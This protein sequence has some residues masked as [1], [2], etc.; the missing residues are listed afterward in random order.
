MCMFSH[1]LTLTRRWTSCMVLL[2]EYRH[3]WWRLQLLRLGISRIKTTGKSCQHTV[4]SPS[5]LCIVRTHSNM[6]TLQ[7]DLA[8][9]DYY[10]TMERY[11][12]QNSNINT[13][14]RIWPLPDASMMSHRG[15]LNGH[16][17]I[18]S[19]GLTVKSLPNL[20][21]GLPPPWALPLEAGLDLTNRTINTKT[22]SSPSF[23]VY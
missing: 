14:T 2:T 22:L 15:L 17:Q 11:V 12:F 6:L 1:T 18:K 5:V 20:K 7:P 10:S 8:L 3:H 19:P 21:H 16:S 9:Q 13:H 4:N 23:K